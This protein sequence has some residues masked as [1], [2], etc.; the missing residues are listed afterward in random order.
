M[1]LQALCAL[2][3][4]PGLVFC[5]NKRSE[6]K[7]QDIYSPGTDCVTWSPPKIM[8]I[9]SL[10]FVLMTYLQQDSSGGT[11]EWDFF[12]FFALLVEKTEMCAV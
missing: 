5:E 2:L 9:C 7:Q 3:R 8:F 11:F 10:I 6:R 12:F 4:V 1:C